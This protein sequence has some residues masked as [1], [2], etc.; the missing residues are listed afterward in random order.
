M[1]LILIYAQ[2]RI[3]AA[4]VQPVAPFAADAKETRQRLRLETLETARRSRSNSYSSVPNADAPK[5]AF[6]PVRLKCS[7][8]KNFCAFPVGVRGKGS[9]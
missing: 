1:L 5:P 4:L 9:V 2:R 8:S 3:C 7:T 6:Q